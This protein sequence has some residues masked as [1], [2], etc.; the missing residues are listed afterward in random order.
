MDLTRVLGQSERGGT[1]DAPSSV[2]ILTPPRARPIWANVVCNTLWVSHVNTRVRNESGVAVQ[3][4]HA[5]RLEAKWRRLREA[6]AD[7]LS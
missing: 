2:M 4:S 3:R 6:E 7:R 5:L 1:R